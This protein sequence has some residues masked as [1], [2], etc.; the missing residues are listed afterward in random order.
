VGMGRTSRLFVDSACHPCL[1]HDLV[2]HLPRRLLLSLLR[3]C[4]NHKTV[5]PATTPPGTMIY[6]ATLISYLIMHLCVLPSVLCVFLQES[7][8]FLIALTEI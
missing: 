4:R 7:F 2:S 6:P 1:Y 8:L 5:S 3:I